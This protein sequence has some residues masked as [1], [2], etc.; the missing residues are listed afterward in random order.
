[1][2]ERTITYI[3]CDWCGKDSR[4]IREWFS[5]RSEGDRHDFC[6]EKCAN[7]FIEKEYEE[8]GER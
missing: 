3:A 6:S 7:S 4:D 2:V 8:G 1:M 5:L